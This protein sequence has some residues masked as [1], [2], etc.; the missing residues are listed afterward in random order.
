MDR[1]PLFA[2]ASIVVSAIL[3]AIG[4]YSGDD[5]HQTRQ[6]LIVLAIVIVAAAIVFWVVV[7]RLEGGTGSAALVLGVLAV[8]SLVLFWLGLPAV[9]AGGSTLLALDAR[10]RP[11]AKLGYVNGALAL[12]ALAIVLAAVAAF[13]G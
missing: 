5:S 8:V 7:P 3:T 9:L 4:T 13:A 12:S 1:R 2:V 6:F 10:E 11:G